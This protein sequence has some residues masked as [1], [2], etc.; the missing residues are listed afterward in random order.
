MKVS[1]KK[2]SFDRIGFPQLFNTFEFVRNVDVSVFFSN[3]VKVA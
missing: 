1:M 3:T 2:S